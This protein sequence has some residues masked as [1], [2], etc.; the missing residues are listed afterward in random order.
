VT[1]ETL[2]ES[3]DRPL[4]KIKRV[5]DLDLAAN[6]K[7]LQTILTSH[8]S[9]VALTESGLIE[10]FL[11]W[12]RAQEWRTVYGGG[13]IFGPQPKANAS[14]HGSSIDQMLAITVQLRWLQ[15]YKGFDQLIAGL[16]NP[17]Q[18]SATIFEIE[19]A[20]W[21]A[22][23]LCTT[24]LTFSPDVVKREKVKHP[25]FLWETNVGALYCECKQANTWQRSEYRLLSQISGDLNDAMGDAD[26]WPTSVRIEVLIHGL[27]RAGAKDRLKAIVREQAIAVRLGNRP[28]VFQDDVFTVKVRDRSVYPEALADSLTHNSIL[29]GQVPVNLNDSRNAYMVVSKSIGLARVKALK[30]L[31]RDAK[32]QLPDAAPSGV[33]VE[34]PSSVDLAAKKLEEMLG[35]SANQSLVWV[36][37]WT[38]GTPHRVVCRDD[39]PFDGRLIVPK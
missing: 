18:I 22:T 34:I 21:C 7:E 14:R 33:F 10:D 16:N 4:E 26:T 38:A 11:R 13:M 17:S 12:F 31:V 3:A 9:L 1:D 15:G 24:A 20:A 37:I 35:Q 2:N 5:L 27:F 30:D 19:A 6:R 39:Q 36:S 23:R 32:K 28:R 25:D 8:P 29:V